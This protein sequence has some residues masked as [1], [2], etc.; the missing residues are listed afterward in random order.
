MSL[1]REIVEWEALN[2]GR[3][4]LCTLWLA[5]GQSVKDWLDW[6]PGNT[7]RLRLTNR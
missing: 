4:P 5:S 6:E 2:D 3:E 7:I 1:Q